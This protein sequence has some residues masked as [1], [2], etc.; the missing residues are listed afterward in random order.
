M[1]KTTIGVIVARTQTPDPTQGHTKLI[2]YSLKNN[3]YTIIFLGVAR[4][5]LTYT[6]P[7]SFEVRKKMLSH[8]ELLGAVILPMPDYKYDSYWDKQLDALIE[9]QFPQKNKRVTL[10]GGRDGVAHTY[11]GKF[12]TKVLDFDINHISAS[13]VREKTHKIIRNDVRWREGVI[14]ASAHKYAVSYQTTDIAIVNFDKKEVLLVQ[15]PGEKKYRFCGGFVDVEDQS[16]EQAAKRE[17]IEQVGQ[18][19]TDNYKYIGSFRVDDFGYRK[20]KD[21]ILTAFFCCY[22][23]YGKPTPQDDLA[24]GSVKWVKIKNLKPG[25]VEKEHKPLMMALIKH[26]VDN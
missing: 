22:Y 7:L 9:K 2:D 12:A 18:I 24:G 8:Y 15:K 10:Y 1:K 6:N 26:L 25:L 17:V 5:R 21:K 16:L 14:W 20:E 19:E 23:I 3:D 4:G 13:A 11:G